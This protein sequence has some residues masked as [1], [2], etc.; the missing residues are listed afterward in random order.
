MEANLWYTDKKE[1]PQGPDHGTTYT[2]NADI[3]DQLNKRFIS[4]GP[5]LASKI[6]HSNENPM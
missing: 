1:N 4:F 3:A 5:L 6:E 2:N